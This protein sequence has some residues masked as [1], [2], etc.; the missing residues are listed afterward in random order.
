MESPNSIP[1]YRPM[2]SIG[3]TA[4]LSPIFCQY[5]NFVSKLSSPHLAKLA[6]SKEYC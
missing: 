3:A 6:P 4:T 5:P 2:F 1:G